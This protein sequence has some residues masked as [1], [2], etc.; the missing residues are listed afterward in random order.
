[1][2][3]VGKMAHWATRGCYHWGK[4]ER[5]SET[6]MG[7]AEEKGEGSAGQGDSAQRLDCRC[8]CVLAAAVVS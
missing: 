2:A 5:G 6:G 8:A 7:V 1:M 3:G 4:M